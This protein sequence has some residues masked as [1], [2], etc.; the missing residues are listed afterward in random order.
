M[1]SFARESAL[2]SPVAGYMRRRGY[3]RQCEEL[4]FFEYSI[5]LYGLSI[6]DAT[7]TAIELKLY[8]WSRAM[9]QAIIYQLCADFVYVA[10]PT[11]TIANVQ[12]SAFSEHGIGLISVAEGPRCTI[13]LD[14]KPSRVVV[15]SYRKFYTGLLRGETET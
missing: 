2:L 1:T 15:E 3:S 11:A 13:V 5:D 7:T 10:L 8:R 14:A 12:L 4:Q 6:R 9:Q